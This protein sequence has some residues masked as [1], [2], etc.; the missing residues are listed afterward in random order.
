MP[1]EEQLRGDVI[2]RCALCHLPF[3]GLPKQLQ[4]VGGEIFI[5]EEVG[6]RDVERI[7]LA[8]G[9]ERFQERMLLVFLNDEAAYLR[10]FVL[11]TKSVKSISTSPGANACRT[12]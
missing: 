6:P 8:F 2:N 5:I 12:R 4:H 7:H 9:K 1:R 3:Q 10:P 11:V